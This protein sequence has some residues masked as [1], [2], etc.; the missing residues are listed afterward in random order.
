MQHIDLDYLIKTEVLSDK[1]K[2]FDVFEYLLSD[3]NCNNFNE[4]SEL[5]H[6]LW[7]KYATYSKQSNSLNGIVFEAILATAFLQHGISPIYVQ[8]KVVFVPNVD[9]DFILYSSEHGPISISAKTSLR[10]R[11]KQADLESVSLKYVHRKAK[12]FLVT[13]HAEEAS[14]LSKKVGNGDM[15]GIDEVILANSPDFD[16]LIQRLKVMRFIKPEPV[17]IVTASKVLQNT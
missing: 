17:Q 11:Y 5:V 16:G 6:A 10:E 8:A 1:S 9:F 7:Q 12:C 15:L 4:A 3:I 14:S 13:L 2:C